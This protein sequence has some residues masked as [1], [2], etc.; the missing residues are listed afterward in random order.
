MTAVGPPELRAPWPP[1]PFPTRR[2]QESKKGRPSRSS[3]PHSRACRLVATN[4]GCAESDA[5]SSSQSLRMR[6][7]RFGLVTRRSG[8]NLGGCPRVETAELG[9]AARR[10]PLARKRE[11]RAGQ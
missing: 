10:V 7:A 5:A 3:L 2:R 8:D 4:K 9:R 11:N 6:Q 1:V